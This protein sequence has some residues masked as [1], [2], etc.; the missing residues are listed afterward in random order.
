M[1]VYVAELFNP[2]ATKGGG[3]I[4]PPRGGDIPPTSFCVTHLLHME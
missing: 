3:G 4:Y 1:L 2:Q